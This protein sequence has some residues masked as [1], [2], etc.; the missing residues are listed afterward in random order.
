M[1]LMRDTGEKANIGPIQIGEKAFRA[2][3]LKGY[4]R[5]Y[6]PDLEIRIERLKELFL[7]AYSSTGELTTKEDIIQLR[8]VQK[9]KSDI[10][11]FTSQSLR[12]AYRILEKKD[13]D[14]IYSHSRHDVTEAIRAMQEYDPRVYQIN[15]EAEDERNQIRKDTYNKNLQIAINKSLD[16]IERSKEKGFCYLSTRGAGFTG[17]LKPLCVHEEDC[18]VLKADS[19]EFRGTIF[20]LSTEITEDK[21]LS[22]SMSNQI[23][24]LSFIIDKSL[25]PEFAMLSAFVDSSLT[26]PPYW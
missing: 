15:R 1:G 5:L 16:L 2:T 18:L 14:I 3:N 10:E 11:Y 19:F 23:T 22:I 24:S 4:E 21:E 20:Y 26:E 8:N 13:L 9:E 25:K 17:F 7:N 12:K 6:P